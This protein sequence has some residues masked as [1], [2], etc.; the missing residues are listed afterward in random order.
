MYIPKPH[1]ETDQAVLYDLI[2]AH[3][4]GTWAAP[5][6]CELIVNHI[7]FLVDPSRGT[8]GTLMGHVARANPVWRAFSRTLPS[9]VVFHGPDTYISPSWYPSK[10]AH[11]R[12]VPTWN[13]VVV[14]AHGI[15]RVVDDSAWL[16]EHLNRLTDTHETGR[17]PAWKVAD[18]P[19]DFVERMI[20]RLVGI[21]IPLAKLEGKWKVSQNRPHADKL[22]VVAGLRAESSPVSAEMAAWVERYASRGE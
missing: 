3:P 4:L 17:S 15:P 2:R 13:Y 12:V 21:E 16:L 8:F 22:G 14:H 19:P 9:V 10:Q 20:E 7:P 1:E 11:G 6:D 5:G 18:A